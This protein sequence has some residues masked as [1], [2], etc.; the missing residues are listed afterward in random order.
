[1]EWRNLNNLHPVQQQHLMSCI[2]R[3]MRMEKKPSCLP[4][5][6]PILTMASMKSK[7]Y[8]VRGYARRGWP[9]TANTWE[10]LENL[11]SVPDLV[12]A[13]EDSLK[14][15]KH[16]KRKRKHVDVLQ[17]T[18]LKKRSERS[19]TSYSL[20]HFP[21]LTPTN[22]NDYDPKLSELKAPTHTGVQLDNLAIHFQQP[23]PSRGAK[24]RKSASSVKRFKRDTDAAA[25]QPISA[26]INMPDANTA[27]N[28]V[29]IIKPIGYSASLSD[30]MHDV[31]VTF[32]AMR[33]DGT[34]VMVDNRYLKAYNPLLL[35]NF[36][37]M[38]LRYTPT[39]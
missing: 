10:P 11:Q 34:E 12:D 5:P 17:L 3:K 9:E 21:P 13:F 35:I 27:C 25:L 33:S 39:P 7:P 32:M 23:I 30:N 36:Y 2:K 18:L 14:S 16:Q 26:P 22:A 19:T 6:I 37:E 31:L 29:K 38:H 8:A 20:R 1:M 24:R 15:G 28:I 4:I